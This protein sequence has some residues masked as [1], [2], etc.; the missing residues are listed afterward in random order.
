MIPEENNEEYSL[1]K[2][3]FGFTVNMFVVIL[4]I[5]EPISRKCIYQ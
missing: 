5:L 2:S 3:T 4:R 1:M